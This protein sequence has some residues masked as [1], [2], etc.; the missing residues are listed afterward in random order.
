MKVRSHFIKATQGVAER[1]R[2]ERPELIVLDRK[3]EDKYPVIKVV[4]NQALKVKDIFAR[5]LRGL[6]IDESKLANRPVWPSEDMSHDS[7]D[8]GEIQ[9]MDPMERKDL[10]RSAKFKVPKKAEQPPS[11]SA[12]DNPDPGP[13]DPKP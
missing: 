1:K 3:G 6:P 4:P 2:A 11:P 12:K 10:A 8:M 9:R 5:F 13:G 7:P